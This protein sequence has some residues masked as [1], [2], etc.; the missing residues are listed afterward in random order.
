V[1]AAV[2]AGVTQTLCARNPEPAADRSLTGNLVFERDLS[3]VPG[4]PWTIDAGE[5][6]PKPGLWACVARGASA[7]VMPGPWSAP[8][9]TETVQTGFYRPPAGQTR[10]VDARGPVYRMTERFD[11]LTAGGKLTVEFR[12]FGTR[13]RTRIRTRIGRGGLASFRFTLPRLRAGELGAHYVEYL[14]F[15]GTQL[16]AARPAFGD[17]AIDAVRSPGGRVDL[18][19]TAPCQ[20]RRC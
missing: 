13:Q 8:T 20:L 1:T 19:F 6:F 10:L 4:T 18:Q 15:A 17:V 2:G 3:G 9:A 7:G 11:P 14:S 5:L 16:V 12:R